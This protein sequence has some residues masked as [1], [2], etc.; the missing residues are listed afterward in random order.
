MLKRS[1]YFIIF[2][3]KWVMKWKLTST[4]YFSLLEKKI[5]KR[6]HQ[7]PNVNVWA[8]TDVTFWAVGYHPPCPLSP[9]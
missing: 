1:Y 4:N 8:H 9:S 5:F 6:A 2:H 3:D 7:N